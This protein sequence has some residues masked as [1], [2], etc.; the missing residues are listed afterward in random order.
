M[1]KAKGHNLARSI[2]EL[3]RKTGFAEATV[4]K[5]VDRDDWMFGRDPRTKPW[6]IVEVKAW[7]QACVK[8]DPATAYRKRIK[9]AESGTGEFAGAGKLTLV[10]IQATL[11]MALLRRQIREERAKKLHKNDVCSRLSSELVH[12]AKA[13][14]RDMGASLQKALTNVDGETAARLLD[15]RVAEILGE[16]ERGMARIAE[17][18]HE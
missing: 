18:A 5:W 16:L 13:A 1:A 10:R 15:A 12:A 11:E 6:N 3:A 8:A 14:F 7:H 4:R 9:A 17:G 2:R